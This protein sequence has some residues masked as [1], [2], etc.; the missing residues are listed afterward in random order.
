MGIQNLLFIQRM[1]PARRSQ[2]AGLTIGLVLVGLAH[3][4]LR[5]G[6]DGEMTRR[7]IL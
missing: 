7:C 2:L 4:R 1:P 3:V 5:R 6:R